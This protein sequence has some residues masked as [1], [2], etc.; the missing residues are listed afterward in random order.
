MVVSEGL[1]HCRSF[2]DTHSELTLPLLLLTSPTVHCG[3]NFHLQLFR[4]TAPGID[5]FF[6]FWCYSKR[7]FLE[8][9]EASNDIIIRARTVR[10]KVMQVLL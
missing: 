5:T 1:T 9:G 7:I 8:S 6:H 10:K 4:P 3:E 2:H